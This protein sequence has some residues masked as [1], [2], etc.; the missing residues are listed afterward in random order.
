MNFQVWWE[1]QFGSLPPVGYM[2]RE[3]L[4]D[5]WFRIHSLPESKRYPEEPAE[6]DEI[7]H[8]H[9][10][11]ASDVLG[12]GS[13]CWVVLTT[14]TDDLNSAAAPALANL[15]EKELEQSFVF[16]EPPDPQWED[17][18]LSFT[19]CWSARVKW[20]PGQF[21]DLIRLVADAKAPQS[22]FVEETR[23]RIYAPYDGGA[24]LILESSQERDM[25]RSKYTEWLSKHPL[26]L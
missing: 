15:G 10:T 8:R 19:V 16:R 21:D 23:S 24:D 9:N 12:N 2:L 13:T 25:L 7:L 1:S 6:Y 20:I 5:R 14:H 17:D 4:K 18:F 26:G 3:H 22:L 11:V